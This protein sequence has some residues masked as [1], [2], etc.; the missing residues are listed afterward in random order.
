MYCAEN[1]CNET[2]YPSHH[3]HNYSGTDSL[4]NN[5]IIIKVNFMFYFILLSSVHY[6]LVHVHAFIIDDL[7]TG[8]V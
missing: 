1:C 7:F 6:C 3:M 8:F 5:T 4:R 2:E